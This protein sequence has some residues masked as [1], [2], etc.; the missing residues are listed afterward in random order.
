MNQQS[1]SNWEL[2]IA[3]G[4]EDR[5]VEEYVAKKLK[6]NPKIRYKRIGNNLGIAGNTN[7]AIKMAEGD[8]I[9]FIDHDDSLRPDALFEVVKVI[10]EKD[11]D[12]IYTDEDKIINKKGELGNFFLNRII[13]LII[14][15]HVITS[16]IFL[17][18]GNPF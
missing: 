6:D 15:S 2:C 14:Y 13:L 3:D 16:I 7:E 12:F 1:Y 9:G 17:L 10:N 8:F 5:S 4:S 18:Y 11:P